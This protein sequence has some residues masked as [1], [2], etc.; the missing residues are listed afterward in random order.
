[1][2]R[3]VQECDGVLCAVG[4]GIGGFVGADML[5]DA[6]RFTGY[7]V[8]FADIVEEGRL[9]V[10][11][12]AHDHDDRRPLGSDARSRDE[13]FLVLGGHRSRGPAYQTAAPLTTTLLNGIFGWKKFENNLKIE[14]FDMSIQSDKLNEKLEKAG[15]GRSYNWLGVKGSSPV[16]SPIGRSYKFEVK[17]TYG[18]NALVLGAS[19]ELFQVGTIVGFELGEGGPLLIYVSCP[20]FSGFTLVRFQFV[21]EACSACLKTGEREIIQPGIFVLL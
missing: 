13:L 21:N 1:M 4:G 12:M 11:D 14:R 18:S 5:G 7:D 9:A 16:I 10:V 2:P 15:L 8:C 3:R 17:T 6:A 20:F 19:R